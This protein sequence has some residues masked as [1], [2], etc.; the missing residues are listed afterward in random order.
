MSCILISC[1]RE[2]GSNYFIFLE[3]HERQGDMC[4]YIHTEKFQYI[5]VSVEDKLF[6]EGG[7][8]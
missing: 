1:I 7:S 8:G 3:A 4:V 2:H 5:L 6:L